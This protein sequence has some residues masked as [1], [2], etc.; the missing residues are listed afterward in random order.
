MEAL[1][2]RK[3][4]LCTSKNLTSRSLSDTI[5]Y[6]ILQTIIPEN[7]FVLPDCSRWRNNQFHIPLGTGSAKLFTNWTYPNRV[8]GRNKTISRRYR[9]RYERIC[10]NEKDR[11]RPNPSFSVPVDYIRIRNVTQRLLVPHATRPY[12][13]PPQPAC[14]IYRWSNVSRGFK[15]HWREPSTYHSWSMFS[16]LHRWSGTKPS[17]RRRLFGLPPL[18]E[19]P[20]DRFLLET[21]EC[22]VN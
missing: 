16:H 2:G 10:V 9:G 6:M 15:C 22:S 7:A 13:L 5:K 8:N 1:S 21:K 11:A 19:P 18:I 3:G 12:R 14:P 4:N 17:H 20:R